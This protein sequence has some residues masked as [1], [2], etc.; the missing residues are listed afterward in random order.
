MMTPKPQET[1][2]QE[3]R[4]MLSLAIP[5]QTKR[6]LDDIARLPIRE[7]APYDA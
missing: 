2:L 7:A 4:K 3:V 6:L 5:E 1:T